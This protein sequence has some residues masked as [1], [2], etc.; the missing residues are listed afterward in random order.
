M[1]ISVFSLA[2]L[3]SSFMVGSASA[4]MIVAH[5]GASYD[6]PE[7]TMA[8]FD[9]AWKLHADGVEGDFYLTKD[10]QIACIHDKTAKRTGG[11]D[12]VIEQSTLAELKE[13]EYGKWKGEK[14][15]GEPLPTFADVLK[16]IPSNKKFII[17]LKTGA[18]IVPYL[19]EELEKQKADV[20]RMLIIAFDAEAVKKC[21]ELLPEYR[22]HWL[23]GYKQNKTTKAWTPTLDEVAKTLQE[24]GADGLGTQGN[25]EVVTEEF[26]DTLR[27]RGMKEF[28]V[29]TIDEP[30]DAKYFQSLGP[31]GV[32]TNRPDLIR[33]TLGL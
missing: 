18:A 7:N 17:E 27:K 11:K 33:S 8:A 1:R 14:F 31:V 2:V 4:Q 25:R 6:A 15:A 28:H 26:I 16:G 23:T 13:M 9:L 21:K 12:L 30:E 32:T 10:K 22:V 19:K 20:S 24:T 29:W 5:R 3:A